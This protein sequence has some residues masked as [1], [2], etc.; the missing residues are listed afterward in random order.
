MCFCLGNLLCCGCGLASNC[1]GVKCKTSRGPVSNVPYVVLFFLASVFAIIMSLYGEEKL[2]VAFWD[3]QVCNKETCQGNGS[4]YRTSFMLFIFELIHLIVIGFGYAQF[5]YQCFIAKLLVF[6]GALTGVF[7]S[8]KSNNFFNGYSQFSRF[9]SIVYLLLQILILIT[10][11]Y[12]LSIY[13]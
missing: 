10:V 7:F 8:E 3:T 9:I 5:H 2:K 6:I 13:V 1:C 4:V 11:G 12:E